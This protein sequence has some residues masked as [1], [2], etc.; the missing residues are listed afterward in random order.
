[1]KNKS[2]VFAI[3]SEEKQKITNLQ[4]HIPAR[5]EVYGRNGSANK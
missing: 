2:E 4:R 1:M 5:T 3:A